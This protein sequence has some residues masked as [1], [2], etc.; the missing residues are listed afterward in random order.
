[1]PKHLERSIKKIGQKRRED[2]GGL[3]ELL[4]S[5]KHTSALLKFHI[6]KLNYTLFSS[7]KDIDTDIG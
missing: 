4:R 2:E 5:L 6:C 7:E 3:K 1:M